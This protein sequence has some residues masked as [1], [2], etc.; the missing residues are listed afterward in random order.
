MAV[1]PGTRAEQPPAAGRVP[2][3]VDDDQPAVL[4]PASEGAVLHVVESFGAG[5]AAAVAGI[6]ESVPLFDHHLLYRP[7]SAVADL[8]LLPGRFASAN[9]FEDKAFGA[10]QQLKELVAEMEPD[11]VHAHSSWAGLLSRSVRLSTPIVYSPHCYAYLRTDIGGVKR[12]V[13]RSVERAL[14]YRTDLLLANGRYEHTLAS[15]LGY[16][17][18]AW[19]TMVS[20][21]LLR[22]SR[23]VAPPREGEKIR[24][25]TLG[26][27][28]PQKSPSFFAEV[29]EAYREIQD[30]YDIE[31]LW[32]GGPDFDLEPPA[33]LPYPLTGWLSHTEVANE[34]A[35]VSIMIH[36]ADWEAGIPISVMEALSRS[37]PTLVRTL[38]FA[39][40][41]DVIGCDT[42]QEMAHRVHQTLRNR[43]TWR[44]SQ[45]LSRAIWGS[46]TG[47]IAHHPV[48][49]VYRQL[50][51]GAP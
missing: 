4:A 13:F 14:A 31:W 34:L 28:C 1:A 20:P 21:D 12:W 32:I 47:R 43:H 45:I 29:I 46:L 35:Q 40:E 6:A 3:L 5:V 24:I 19:T 7:R 37:I 22:L 44:E 2:E 49:D 36:C 30:G 11:V 42:P 48:D 23:P 39:P 41:L 10:R 51:P 16:G 18:S 38:P 50:L 25:A 17:T 27:W 33:D 15:K 8:S 26:R 9:T